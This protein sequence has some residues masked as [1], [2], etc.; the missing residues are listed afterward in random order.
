MLVCVYVL[1]GATDMAAHSAIIMHIINNHLHD[2]GSNGHAYV[3]S[4][5]VRLDGNRTSLDR[6][7]KTRQLLIICVCCVFAAVLFACQCCSRAAV[8]ADT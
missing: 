6:L 7:D 2:L 8:A 5:R 1:P 4:C 3:C